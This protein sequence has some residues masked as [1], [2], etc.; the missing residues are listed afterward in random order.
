[1]KKIVTLECGCTVRAEVTEDDLV[2]RSATCPRHWPGLRT[3]W[4]VAS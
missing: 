2:G 1:M 4:Q 3:A